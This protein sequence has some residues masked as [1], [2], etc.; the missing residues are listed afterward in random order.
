M[1]GCGC[2]TAAPGADAGNCSSGQ[3]EEAAACS[4]SEAFALRVIGHSM[5]PEFSEGEIILIEPDGALHHG[6]YVLAQAE[7]EWTFR[8]LQ[9]RGSDWW[10][11]PLNPAWPDQKLPDL[12]VVHGRIIQA[13]VPG[14]R[15][16]T[17]H[18]V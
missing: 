11:H 10:L 18:Y 5:A 4:G 1:S 6:C 16:L 3:D 17:R 8:Q 14:R 2:E 13:A 9:Q 12:S 15:K 7:G